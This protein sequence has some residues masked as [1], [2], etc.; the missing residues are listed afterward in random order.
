MSE[1]GRSKSRSMSSRR[2]CRTELCSFLSCLPNPAVKQFDRYFVNFAISIS[3]I[4]E[5][6][7]IVIQIGILK[8]AQEPFLLHIHEVINTENDLTLRRLHVTESALISAVLTF[9]WQHLQHYTVTRTEHE[10]HIQVYVYSYL[11]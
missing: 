4:D 7:S 9:H 1:Y 8:M 10:A 11:P 3:N 5:I 2:V 6:C